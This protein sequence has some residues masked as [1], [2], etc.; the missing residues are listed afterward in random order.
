MKTLLK[1][2]IVGLV[3]NAAY[4]CGDAAWRFYQWKDSAYEML[5]L[6][7]DTDTEK[8]RQQIIHRASDLNLP[9]DSE[10]VTVTRQ[11]LRTAARGS[12][13]KPVEVFPGYRYPYD[14]DFNVEVVAL[15]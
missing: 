2:I 6:G 5:T 8:L 13:Q 3:L 15:R 7:V 11:G 4:R 14:F 9:V 10:N 1:L 12:Y